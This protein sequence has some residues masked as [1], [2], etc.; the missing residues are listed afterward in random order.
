MIEH[1]F[2]NALQTICVDSDGRPVSLN[3]ILNVVGLNCLEH[4]AVLQPLSTEAVEVVIELAGSTARSLEGQWF[5]AVAA[6][7]RPLEVV[8]M[9][10][11]L[12]A[13]LVPRRAH[14][15]NLCV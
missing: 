2:T 9:N 6:V 1:E 14:S 3:Q 5:A 11:R 13:T 10:A 8:R 7:D 15:L 4:A 12:F